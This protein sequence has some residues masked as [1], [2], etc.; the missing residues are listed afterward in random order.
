M[1]IGKLVLSM[2][3]VV[4]VFLSGCSAKKGDAQSLKQ[5]TILVESSNF[6]PGFNMTAKGD[7]SNM[8]QFVL[9]DR[10]KIPFNQSVVKQTTEQSSYGPSANIPYFTVRFAIPIP[11]AYTETETAALTGI[12]KGVYTHSHSP[13]F[14][15]LPN[16]DALAIYFSAPVG[17]SENDTTTT[18]VQSRLR[19]GSEDWDMPEQF[20]YT[21]GGNDQS[22]LLWNDNGKIWFFGGGR[23]IS[24]YVP[25]RIATSTDNGASWTFSIPQLDSIATNYTA[26]PIVNA[27]RDPSGAIYMAMDGKDS[28]S[29]LWRSTDEGKTWHD[30]G[31]RTGGRHST[32]VPLDDKG[33][34]LS[35]G[36]KNADVDGWSPQNISHD[37]GATW[38]ESVASPFPP[39]GSVQRP[40]L[41]KLA[42]GNLLFVSDSYM[43]KKKIA[44][45]TG[46]KYGNDA[47]VAIS[48]DNGKTWR[49]KTL[50]VQLPQR[51]RPPY[52]SLGYST[53]RQAPNGVI[54]LLTTAGYPPI[55]YEFNE[56]W[57][58]SD[59]ADVTPE[60]SGGE[61]KNFSEKYSDGKLKSTWSARIC[62]NGRYLLHGELIDYY[63]DG[64]KQHQALY[65]NGR[66]TG[67]ETYWSKDGQIEW[68]WQRDLKKKQ[69]IWTQYWPN[70]NKK[71]ESVW[72]IKPEA[73]DLKR[74]FNGYVADGPSKHWDES[75]NLVE[76][77]QFKKGILVEDK[78]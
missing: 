9:E 72:N 30:M 58:W 62:P 37:W 5:D 47:F 71:V 56:A 60:S 12:D 19:Y 34:L 52:G 21:R 67:G 1:K 6:S 41:I 13:G 70:G 48:K 76:T 75:G 53:V 63:P 36:G 68:M 35:I 51:H 15:I 78:K 23:Y 33:T 61:V 38:S 39:L 55:H 64:S 73:R 45:P 66:K 17:K 20:F 11:P 32:I 31:G 74:E 16:G 77:Y 50:P 3:P 4:C 69:G 25:F 14:E 10:G 57:V 18:F 7:S 8:L 42:S 43:H 26:Q 59:A 40:C 46:W 27:F 28:R 29:F 22:G 44:P 54:H 65:E 24:D 2:A 49:I